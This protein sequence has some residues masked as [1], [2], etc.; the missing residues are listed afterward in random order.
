MDKGEV[1]APDLAP[2]TLD[3]TQAAK[4]AWLLTPFDAPAALETGAATVRQ[5]RDAAEQLVDANWDRILALASELAR[6]KEMDR[7]DIEPY[8]VRVRAAEAPG[9]FHPFAPVVS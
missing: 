5:L 1:P 6:R 3:S 4:A 9:S 2:M 8:L 7:A